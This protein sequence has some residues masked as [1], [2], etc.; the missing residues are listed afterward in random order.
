MEYVPSL[1]STN[2][3]V[4][5]LTVVGAPALTTYVM[6]ATP[7]P[8]GLSV[9]VSVTVTAPLFHPALFGAGTELAVLVG[10]TAS[11]GWTVIVVVAV[12]V[13]PGPV[14]VSV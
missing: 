10:G 1:E 5:P 8:P 2:H 12:A 7:L 6:D 14:A 13:P 9:A 3:A 11:L 4:A